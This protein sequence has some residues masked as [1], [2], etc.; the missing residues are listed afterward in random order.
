M[1]EPTNAQ[2]SAQRGPRWRVSRGLATVVVA[3]AGL[4]V[5]SAI[6]ASS[7]TSKGAL[8]SMLPFAAVLAIAALGQT[9]VVQQGGID[10]SIAGS[11]SLAIVIVTHYP[12]GDDSKLLPAMAI[13]LVVAL[14]AGL[15]NGFLV[16]VLGL[17]PI[18]ATLGHERAALRRRARGLERH[19]AHDHRPP[20]ERG[21]RTSPSAFPT[22]STTPSRRPPSSRWW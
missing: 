16:G 12:D 8:L 3:T 18:V 14:G 1:G 20:R 4:F 9:L 19:P 15:G 6:F 2:R 13:S 11:M 17:N 10:L 22:R 7:S 5:V 21:R